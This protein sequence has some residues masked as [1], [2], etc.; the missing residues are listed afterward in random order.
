MGLIDVVDCI[1]AGSFPDK[2]LV[3]TFDD[4]YHSV[5]EQAFPVLQAYNLTATVFLTVGEHVANQSFGRLPTLN[6]M[7]M[8]DWKEIR[9]MYR[10]GITFGAHTQTHPDLTQLSPA[11]IERE[12]RDSKAI[13]EDALGAPVNCFA[14]PFGRF[15][16]HSYFLAGKYFK[17][18]CSD[19][20]D[21]ITNASDPY[22]L[23][24]I[25]AYYLRTARLFD[26]FFTRYFPAYIRLCAI[27]R[28]IK[29]RVTS[30]PAGL[31]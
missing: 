13:I 31:D 29:R 26:L 21:F 8:L 9:E 11:H 20:L 14:Y 1:S 30:F 4:G 24:R 18:A 5:Y 17:C 28:L 2:S 15:N 6:G 12:I 10:W 16:K 19:R 23:E 7:T 22:S 27:P 25:D 3:I